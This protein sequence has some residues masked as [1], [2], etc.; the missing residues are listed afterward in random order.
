MSAAGT[1]PAR[2]P[3]KRVMPLSEA[4]DL[5]NLMPF[6]VCTCNRKLLNSQ[7]Q[8]K[9]RRALPEVY[10]VAFEVT[11]GRE[12]YRFPKQPFRVL[13]VLTLEEFKRVAPWA[14]VEHEQG[15]N[16]YYYEIHTD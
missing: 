15:G 10:E 9:S 13:R 3:H 7:L 5:M 2:A 1:A 12:T 11:N 8:V 6:L 4:L 14:S 16:T